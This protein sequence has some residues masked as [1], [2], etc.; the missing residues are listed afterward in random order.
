M[1]LLNLFKSFLFWIIFIIKFNCVKCEEN[2][3]FSSNT[4]VGEYVPTTPDTRDE[5]Q[6]LGDCT[7]LPAIADTVVDLATISKAYKLVKIKLKISGD[8]GPFMGP[9]NG[10][11]L[12][13]VS[14]VLTTGQSGRA[15]LLLKENSEEMS[16]GALGYGVTRLNILLLQNPEHCLSRGT[17]L[18]SENSVRKA[19]LVGFKNSSVA[20][21]GAEV[22]NR[23]ID[24]SQTGAATLIYK[25]CR[26]SN[27]QTMYCYT[28]RPSHWL[29]IL[30]VLVV[31]LQV[32][33]VVFSPNFI[34]DSWAKMRSQLVTYRFKTEPGNI[35]VLR[36]QKLVGRMEDPGGRFVPTKAQSSTLRLNDFHDMV[37]ALKPNNTMVIAIKSVALSLSPNKLLQEG[38]SPVSVLAFLWDFL[39]RCK[40]RREIP[41]LRSCCNANVIGMFSDKRTIPWYVFFR[42]FMYIIVFGLLC[43]PWII[44]VWF[45]F[46]YELEIVDQQQHAFSSRNLTLPF[47]GSLVSYMS[48]IHPL[49]LV[50]YAFLGC[51][52]L[53][54][55]IFPDVLKRKMK[56]TVQKCLHDLQGTEV[57]DVCGACAKRALWP[58]EKLG[59]VG[60]LVLP[61][62][63]LVIVLLFTICVL[64]AFPIV[65]LSLRLFVNFTFYLIGTISPGLSAC[66]LRS[67]NVVIDRVRTLIVK[68]EDS[69]SR[70]HYMINAVALAV[71]LVTVWF[72]MLLVTECIAF[73]AT[74]A[75]Y[76]LIGVILN[77]VE[78]L[79][80]IS[81]VLLIA[82]YAYD[83]FTSAYSGYAAFCKT[84]HSEMID[85]I[86]SDEIER[87]SSKSAQDQENTAFRVR[88]L[89]TK[90]EERMKLVRGKGGLLNW[91]APR[92]C[93]F[94]DKYDNPFIPKRMLF[95]MAK[96][97]HTSCPKQ[98]HVIY[99]NAFLDFMKVVA[100]LFFVF[101][102]I[103]AFGQAHDVPSGTQA[104]VALGSGFLP[105]V[106]RQFL[107]RSN[108][109]LTVERNLKWKEALKNAIEAYRQCWSLEDIEADIVTDTGGDNCTL[110]ENVENQTE[111]DDSMEEL[112]NCGLKDFDE[113]PM[114]KKE[115]RIAQSHSVQGVSADIDL[116]LVEKT[117][118]GNAYYE[119]FVPEDLD[120][121]AGMDA[122]VYDERGTIV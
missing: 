99:L 60:C 110:R 92:L 7:L 27:E 11:I 118:H 95:E 77:P 119:Y 122:N 106:F 24:V 93:L 35:L 112:V 9:N 55:F 102:V 114:S 14:W 3:S 78:T 49:F 87:V 29:S 72:I 82:I 91:C 80:F 8:T 13:P 79:K 103:F 16:L 56:S 2:V 39:V 42:T 74:C 71:T 98:P 28:L 83:C 108:E 32:A 1:D 90:N 101:V 54:W 46:K 70:M 115:S 40:L 67:S 107:F 47:T 84:I 121:D 25:C 97:D 44:R 45:Y 100:F 75:V 58:L 38:E 62:W 113:L 88:S 57:L 4:R 43:S 96:I 61:L 19:I 117:K 104:L 51:E 76:T 18:Q 36:V 12:N 105:L 26:L 50:I 63:V 64:V 37:N 17:A 65:N 52:T 30:I 111:D 89:K 69:N 48:P 5:F 73:Y 10:L 120:A 109:K 53:L 66:I 59:I 116:V 86:G 31:I 68:N 22:C 41:S 33:V 6:H 20:I 23:H 15:M 81:L 85:K 21:E 34:P 94:L